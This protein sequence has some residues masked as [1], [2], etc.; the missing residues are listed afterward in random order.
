MRDMIKTLPEVPQVAFTGGQS[1]QRVE[2]LFQNELPVLLITRE[3]LKEQ[4]QNDN[5]GANLFF[6]FTLSIQLSLKTYCC[7]QG[8][9]TQLQLADV[10]HKKGRYT[11]SGHLQR[12]E[13]YASYEQQMAWIRK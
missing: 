12:E 1:C 7:H 5:S 8:D 6:S 13:S 9:G 11:Q 2:D 4:G 3:H 10:L